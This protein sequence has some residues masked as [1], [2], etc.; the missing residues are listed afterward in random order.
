MINIFLPILRR[1][2]LLVLF[3]AGL[4]ISATALIKFSQGVEIDLTDFKVERVNLWWLLAAALVHLVGHWLR[5]INFRILFKPI[6]TVSLTF[7]FKSLSIGYLFNS[8]LPFRLGELIRANIIG[9]SLRVSR[10]VVL[11][12]IAIERLADV[13]VLIGIF[14]LT[15]TALGL[16]GISPFFWRVVGW[17]II[18]FFTAVGFI[19]ILYTQN[20][21]FLRLVASISEFFNESIKKKI[22]FSIWTLIYGVNLI[23]SNINLGRYLLS[24]LLMWTCYLVAMGLLLTAFYPS[25]KILTQ[26]IISLSAYFCVSIPSGPA[27]LGTYHYYFSTIVNSLAGKEY[28]LTLS[29]F[30]WALM[31]LPI[32]I[33]GGLFVIL[34]NKFEKYKIFSLFSPKDDYD[35]SI[36]NSLN[37]LYRYSDVSKELDQFLEAY[38]NGNELSR[39]LGQDEMGGK[40]RVVK[41]FSGG[42]NAITSVVWNKGKKIVRKSVLTPYAEKLRNQYLWLEE[43]KNLKHIPKTV[44]TYQ[45]DLSFS[46]D[47]EYYQNYVPFF[48]FIHNNS[49]EKSKLLLKKIIGFVCRD[50]YRDKKTVKS[51]T[52][53]ERYIKNK[54]FDKLQD[55][56]SFNHNL[57]NL[58]NTD[59][60]I[61]NGKSYLNF[62]L[63]INKII[64]DNKLM[65]SL[66]NFQETTIH[67]DLT[68]ENI[69][70]KNNDFILLDPNDENFISDKMVDFAK[71]YQSL[72]SGYE[73]L[74]KLDK[75]C[76]LNNSINFEENISHKYSYLFNFLETTLKEKIPLLE[77]K[78]IKFHEAVHYFRM[79][80]YRARINPETLPIFYSV[81]IRL[82]NEFYDD[83][84]LT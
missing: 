18:L 67:G 12:V 39:R 8:I 83:Y 49:L 52:I 17:L 77:I 1:R 53:V 48:E 56:I 44:G 19:F 72:H 73:F 31:I 84:Y 5:A 80:T 20:K 22:R 54:V 36:D 60:I 76:I 30:T 9:K 62:D 82:F 47:L 13:L 50:I 64:K 21:N 4:T 38:F 69:L 74:C 24:V 33:I 79:L 46:I 70:V 34:L 59:K 26:I 63:I 55:T 27:F 11:V 51:R 23:I 15:T 3:L 71:L 28:L 2:L 29:I 7:I 65:D 78:L 75:V 57:G 68:I 6:K 61:I 43:R 66:A 37:K 58:V 25:I 35:N 45:D 81:G 40:F 16:T 10:M 42:S 14:F 32:S 41:V